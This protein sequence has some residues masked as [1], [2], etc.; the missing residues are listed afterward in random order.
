LITSRSKGSNNKNTKN[1]FHGLDGIE[2]KS[3]LFVS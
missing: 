1:L 2:S 3:L